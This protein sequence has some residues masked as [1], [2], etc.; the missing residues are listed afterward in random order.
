MSPFHDPDELPRAF[1]DYTLIKPLG[2]GGMGQVYL[3]QLKGR[4]LSGVDKICV[5]KTLRPTNDPEYERR[6]IDEARLIVLLGHKNICPTF[7]AG[8]FE[9]EYYLAMEHVAGRELR[10]LQRAAEVRGQP[11]PASVVIHILKEIL[12]GLDA[13]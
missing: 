6:F 5:I 7:D 8:C 3:A 10:T 11:M 13:A 2:R 12:E 1:G 4:G 9:G